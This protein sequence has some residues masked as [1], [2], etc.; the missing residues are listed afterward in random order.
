MY[1]RTG[2]HAC[3]FASMIVCMC[4]CLLER[5]CSGVSVVVCVY[6]YV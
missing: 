5:V 3:V 2:V 4:V 1:V 6:S